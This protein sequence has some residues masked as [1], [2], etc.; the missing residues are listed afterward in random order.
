MYQ[1]YDAREVWHFTKFLLTVCCRPW[2]STVVVPASHHHP[3]ARHKHSDMMDVYVHI[4]TVFWR[5]HESA[6]AAAVE[7]AVLVVQVHTVHNFSLRSI[8][9]FPPHKVCTANVSVCV[10]VPVRVVEANISPS[11]RA[12]LGLWVSGDAKIALY[13]PSTVSSLHCGWRPDK[14]H[15]NLPYVLSRIRPLVLTYS[16]TCSINFLT[17]D[18]IFCPNLTI[19]EISE[20]FLLFS[21]KTILTNSRNFRNCR[22]KIMTW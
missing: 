5:M 13:I 8:I 4:V 1:D 16:I 10:S 6:A 11:A 3:R 12:R 7:M 15:K 2:C 20:F 14:T 21:K 19:I 17:V 22:E 18:R 9:L